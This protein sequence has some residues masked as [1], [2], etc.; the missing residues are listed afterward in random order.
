MS[1]KASYQRS[2]RKRGHGFARAGALVHP[3]IKRASEGRGFASDK[4]LTHWD[5]VAGP[6]LAELCRPVKISYS[7]GGFGATLTVLARSAA[8]PLVQAQLPSLRE[9]VNACYGYNAIARVKVTQTSA[10]GF[11]EDQSPFQQKPK[12]R[13]PAKIDPDTV[14]EA[15]TATETIEDPELRAALSGLGQ[16]ILSRD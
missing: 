5:E 16:R 8:A 1:D 12:N 7:R 2:V 9:R 10:T 11:G 13:A 6:E 15:E 4:V 3:Q 14:Q